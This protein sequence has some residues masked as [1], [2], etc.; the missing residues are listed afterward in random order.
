MTFLDVNIKY[1]N[2]QFVS[3]LYRK[4]TNDV[5][6]LNARSEC[7]DRYKSS[8]IT[9]SI[10]RAYKICSSQNLFNNK[11]KKL[12]QIL[13]NSGYTNAEFDNELK[14]FLL[15][16]DSPPPNNNINNIKIYYKNQMSPSYKIDEKI[17]KNIVKNNT[18]CTDDNEKL[19][20]V[21]YYKSK[22]TSQLIMTNT[23]KKK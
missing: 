13:I 16:K 5:K 22:L 10:R 17:L 7:P 6:L 20:L 8:V 9:G 21:I 18:L 11:I 3:D 15:K 19:E 1:D 23:M 2:K 14:T 12:K 4:S